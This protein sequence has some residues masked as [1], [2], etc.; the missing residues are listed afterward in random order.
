MEFWKLPINGSGEIVIHGKFSEDGN[1][2]G[3]IGPKRLIVGK[4]GSVIG[5]V[6]TTAGIDPIRF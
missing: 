6:A 5:A 4:A 1:S 3:I 2:P